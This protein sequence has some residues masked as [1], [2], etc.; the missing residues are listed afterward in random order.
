[1]SCRFGLL[2]SRS[3][4][5]AAQRSTA[6]R[7]QASCAN[8]EERTDLAL[9]QAIEVVRNLDLAFE[10]AEPPRHRRGIDRRHFCEW[11]PRLCDDEG[12]AACGAINKTG[13]LVL[14]SSMMTVFM[15]VVN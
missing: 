11:L 4:W 6:C 5:P 2:E 14:A 15:A 3:G 1:L 7:A 10:E 12:L 13:K 9:P 8:P